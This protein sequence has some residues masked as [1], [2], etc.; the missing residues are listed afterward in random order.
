MVVT[1]MV[2]SLEDLWNRWN[3]PHDGRRALKYWTQHE[4]NETRPIKAKYSKWKKI[5]D[6]IAGMHDPSLLTLPQDSALEMKYSLFCLKF[7]QHDPNKR[8]WHT[9]LL[10]VVRDPDLSA[11]GSPSE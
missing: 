11:D 10:R 5:C 9:R 4:R 2:S 3:N 6:A 8:G 1:P 7:Q